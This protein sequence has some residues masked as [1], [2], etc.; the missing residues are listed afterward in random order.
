M[1]VDSS[2]RDRCCL[3]VSNDLR[4]VPVILDFVRSVAT[5]IGFSETDRKRIELAVDEAATNVIEHA[6]APD[7]IATFDIICERIPH[8]MEIR[9]RDKGLP[10]DPTLTPE[11]RPDRDLDSQTGKGLGR[12]LIKQ[13]TDEYEFRNLGA[14]GKETRLVK[15][16]DTPSIADEDSGDREPEI[17]E[18]VES[19]SAEPL[20]VEIRWMRPEEAIEIARCVYDSYG[21]SYGYEHIYYPERVLALNESG[22][23]RSAVAAVPSGEIAC[24]FALVF[25]KG[26]PGEVAI[27]VTK[28]KF[29]GLKVAGRV[30]GFLDDQAQEMGLKGLYGKQ[31]TV[32]PYTQKFCSKLG[33]KD[34]GFLLAHVMSSMLFK[35]ISEDTKQRGTDILCFKY[36]EPPEPITIY[37]PEHH[38]EMILKLY[39]NVGVP[40]TASEPE[41]SN[42]PKK[43]TV[44]S[45]NV[46]SKKA[47]AEIRIPEY[48]ENV[49][50]SLRQE[51]RRLRHDEVRVIEMFL[52]LKDPV[53]PLIVPS[54]EELGFL[55]TGILPE[56]G[57]S[58]SMV[59]QCFNGVQVEYDTLYVVSDMAQEL[60]AYIKEND[61]L[62][63]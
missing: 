13:N 51:L 30:A 49:I 9:V 17:P 14:D 63:A 7:E 56:T 45:V 23:L 59:M 27:A 47:L 22:D 41:D 61:P 39:E 62:L 29:R 21:Y 28:Q 4:Y 46:N 38:K 37:P 34:C 25:N 19:T 54:L 36:F 20:E 8:G 16:L 11:Y 10:F 6:F 2:I 50:T 40:V 58:D 57:G 35:G 3:T 26:Y 18:P 55:F 44:M 15:L 60:L 1:S 48:G 24:H 53:T 43:Q 32:H 31:V 12:F 33:Y 5:L 42:L 52:D